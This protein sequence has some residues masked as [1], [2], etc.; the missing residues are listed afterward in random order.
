TDLTIPDTGR[1]A[2]CPSGA[3]F[4]VDNDYD[5]VGLTSCDYCPNTSPQPAADPTAP[6]DPNAPPYVDLFGCAQNQDPIEPP[7]SQT[8]ES[9]TGAGGIQCEAGDKC[10]QG[11]FVNAVDQAGCCVKDPTADSAAEGPFCE[12]DVTNSLGGETFTLDYGPC[13]DADANGQGF[14]EVKGATPE[15]LTSI[16][17]TLVNGKEACTVLPAQKN[18]KV[19]FFSLTSAF[20][21]L[22]LLGLYSF[23][24]V[25]KKRKL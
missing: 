4:G 18:K 7:T 21:S 14:R 3:E 9:C 24:Q 6:V 25:H 13:Q 17:I 19:P 8:F 16:G 20:L 23:F 2:D 5:N 22:L 1:P 11:S 12:R 15:Q 10:S